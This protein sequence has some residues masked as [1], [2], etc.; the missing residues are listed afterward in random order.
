MHK[1]VV[2]IMLLT[3]LFFLLFGC[4]NQEPSFKEGSISTATPSES[5]QKV[6]Y[7]LEAQE[8]PLPPD[9][10]DTWEWIILDAQGDQ[11]LF[12]VQER[13]VAQEQMYSYRLT[14][15]IGLYDVGQA[16]VTA[17]W[18]PET[19]A[20][21]QAGA[22]TGEGTACVAGAKD[23]EH[24]YPSE[25]GLV[26]LGQDQEEVPAISG[27]VQE[28][29]ALE[30]GTA[31]FSFVKPDG[32]F[33]VRAISGRE[34]TDLLTWQAGGQTEPLGGG[35]LS[36]CGSEFGYVYAED[37]RCVLVRA[38]L[39]GELERQSLVPGKEKL[40]SCHLTQ[41]GMVACLSIDED[42]DQFHRELTLLS[43]REGAQ[44]RSGGDGALYRM[45]FSG[46]LGIAVDSRFRL[47]LLRLEDG[48]V[49]CMPA[50]LPE[51]LE[52]VNESTVDLYAA[53]DDVFYVFYSAER[54][55]YRV[56]VAG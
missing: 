40:D 13:Q 20:W 4:E 34:V 11:V 10:E 52:R 41:E 53:G 47:Q 26:L 9:L 6:E 45:R 38:G 1:K 33:G 54:R 32:R 35:E 48:A 24:V 37:G 39:S 55:L 22:I 7:S 18:E 28:L 49:T 3:L 44:R 30:D 56:S 19:P 23:Y 5:E 12:A 2:G 51:E 25:Y 46:E 8:I 21:Y 27:T 50:P 17:R 15:E 31:I 16:C 36:V 29:R 14:R 42:T 43:A